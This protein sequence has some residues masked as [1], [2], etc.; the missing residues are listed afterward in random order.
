MAD[1]TRG[2]DRGGLRDILGL[3]ISAVSLAAFVWWATK[4]ERPEF[5]TGTRELLELAACLLI[6]AGATLLR[7]WRWHTILRR[8]DVDHERS[9]AYALTVVGYMGN[10]VLPA[11]SGELL[12]VLLLGERS[13]AKRRVILGTI[14]AERFLDLLT[15]VTLFAALTVGDVA[16]KPLGLAPLA[17]VGGVVLAG[18]TVLG[19]LKAV[20]RRGRLERF[21][22][23]VRPFAHATRVLVGRTGVV[24]AA[25]TV[26]VWL[27][28]ALIFWLVGDS[29]HLGI[30][31]VEALFLVVLTSFVAI[32]PSA[33]G[34]I[35]TFEAAIV[36]GLNALGIE[37]GQAVAFALLIRFLLYVP[38]TFVGLG[39]MLMRYG[40]LRRL[41]FRSANSA[42]GDG[43]QT[44]ST[45]GGP[46]SPH[47]PEPARRSSQGR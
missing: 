17:L 5:P 22:E 13:T 25:V 1:E 10:N 19:L 30:T 20:R 34:Y 18:A 4:Q 14:I 41:R 24:L 39:L 2:R 7:G 21:A 9:D 15:I 27:L 3:A 16:D 37:G 35:G 11:R 45:R 12:R 33:P 46:G 8:S 43:G 44:P 28:E 26:A 23:I 47:A 31:P 40:G 42:R 6:Y 36:F 32:I 38:I 29:L